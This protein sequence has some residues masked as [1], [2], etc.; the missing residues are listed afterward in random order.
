MNIYPED[1]YLN[2]YRDLKLLYKEYVGKQTL[3]P[4]KTYDKMKTK[5]IIHVT[6][7]RFQMDYLTPKKKR[8]F[9]KYDEDP[10]DTN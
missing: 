10:I 6:D 1:I 2:Q 4:I 7:L 5:Y 3:S 8:L 9:E